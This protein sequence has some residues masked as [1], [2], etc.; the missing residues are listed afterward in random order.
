MS[1]ALACTADREERRLVAQLLRE[2]RQRERNGIMR[3][4]WNKPFSS[5]ALLV[6]LGLGIV[7][8]LLL[9]FHMG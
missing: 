2:E 7:A 6:G 4:S 8:V 9:V 5:A 3:P 1:R